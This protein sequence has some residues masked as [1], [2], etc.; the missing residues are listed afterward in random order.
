MVMENTLN[1]TTFNSLNNP[2][3]REERVE[4]LFQEIEEHGSDVVLLQEVLQDTFPILKEKALQEGWH[5]SEGTRVAHSP[6]KIY[7]NATLSRIPIESQFMLPCFICE[8]KLHIET[9]I[10]HLENNITTINAHLP[11]GGHSELDR[12]DTVYRINQYAECLRD[13]EPDRLII[14]GGDFNATLESSALRYLNGNL[15]YKETSTFWTNSWDFSENIF[16][17]AR[18]EGGWAET[19]AKSVGIMRPELMPNRTIDHVLTYGWNYGKRHSPLSLKK[20]GESNLSNGYGLSD[21]YGITT[22]IS[23]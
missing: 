19:T 8:G 9:L 17:T 4:V 12:L 10:T 16:P 20:F 14:F 7:G 18:K 23:L 1:V 13:Q 11:W 21:H 5:V 22:T 3:H 2:D 15:L 6:L